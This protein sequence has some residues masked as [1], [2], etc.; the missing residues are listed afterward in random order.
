[1]VRVNGL[2]G[3]I[4]L[5]NL[6]TIIL[7]VSFLVLAVGGAVGPLQ[8]LLHGFGM[9]KGGAHRAFIEDVVE[10]PTFSSGS[11]VRLSPQGGGGFA[12]PSTAPSAPS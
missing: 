10:H 9:E 2:F 11:M 3:H 6:K 7:I 4:Q 8:I 1:M 12:A 5:N